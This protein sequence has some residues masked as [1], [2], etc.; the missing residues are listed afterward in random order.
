MEMV[1]PASPSHRVLRLERESTLEARQSI[2]FSPEALMH[3]AELPMRA[4][5]V[6]RDRQ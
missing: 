2:G 1:G 5:M 3:E 4:R 6:G